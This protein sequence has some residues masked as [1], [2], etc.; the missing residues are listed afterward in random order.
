[1]KK[2]PEYIMR[3]LRERLGVNSKDTSQDEEI[4]SMSKETVLDE[5]LNYE[6]II[7]YGG[8]IKDL[9]EMIWGIELE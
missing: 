8:Q 9:V 5:Y 7:G 3:N 2:Y 4:M 1:M 6:G